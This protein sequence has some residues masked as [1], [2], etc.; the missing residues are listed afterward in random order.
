MSEV[1][2]KINEIKELFEDSTSWD[3]EGLVD[4]IL[5]EM[6]ILNGISPDEASLEHENY[7][8]DLESFANEFFLQ[9][10]S[11]VVDVIDTFKDK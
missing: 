9:V 6:I 1:N 3:R 4:D 5:H 10:L 2:C 7:L 11:K 8:A